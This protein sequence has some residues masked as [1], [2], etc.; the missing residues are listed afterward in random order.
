MHMPTV[1]TWQPWSFG[2]I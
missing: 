1:Y 2:C